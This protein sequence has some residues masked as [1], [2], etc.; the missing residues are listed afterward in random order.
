MYSK[1]NIRSLLEELRVRP[2]K[3]HGQNFLFN[4]SYAERIVQAAE[5][6]DNEPVC[7]VGAGL[8]AL[9]NLLVE[10]TKNLL[11]IEQEPQFVKH[12]QSLHTEPNIEI[13]CQDA[14]TFTFPSD[15]TWNLVSNVP[16]SISTD[17]LLWI[18]NQRASITRSTLLFQKEFAARLAATPG[19]KQYGSITVL[20]KVYLEAKLLFT[21]PGDAFYP[22]AEVES[23][24]I[25]F[26]TRKTPLVPTELQ[27]Q[28]TKIVRASFSMRRKT[29]LNCLMRL[30]ITPDK[31]SLHELLLS[32]GIDSKRR[33]ETLSVEE[34]LKLTQLLSN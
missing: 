17:L 12:L 31:E 11:V 7:E 8:G 23:Q 19:N 16:Y 6:K 18:I 34:F 4:K 26:T 5:I 28:F 2:S 20:A 15:T 21:I 3:K 33:G 29:L 14:L 9:T 13:L 24:L 30:N 25:S 32:A 27:E 22:P 10:Q 1:N